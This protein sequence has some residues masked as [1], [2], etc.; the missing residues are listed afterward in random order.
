MNPPPQM[1]PQYPAP[2]PKKGMSGCMIAFIV[3]GA[4]GL[5]TAIVVGVALYFIVTSKSAQTAFK[6]IGEGTKMAQKGLTAPGT[7]ELRA[8]GC[9]QAMVLDLK[10]VG[11]TMM[12]I[13]DAG[14]DGG[15]PEGLMVTCQVRRGKI[16][17]CD[18]VASTYITAVGTASADFTVSVQRSGDN[19]AICEATYDTSGALL[20]HK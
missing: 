6:V 14:I 13:L 19:H 17:S 15:V 2:P 12:D 5:V 11:T 10:E 8:L 9:E 3:V 16:P 18:D 20:S 1:Q 7:N 4:V